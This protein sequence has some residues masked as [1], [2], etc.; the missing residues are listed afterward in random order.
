MSRGSTGP[1]TLPKLTAFW[2]RALLSIPGYEGNPYRAHGAV[3]GRLAFERR[4]F[5]QWLDLFHETLDLGW[6]GPKVEQ[7]KALACKVAFVHSKQITGDPVARE[8]PL[9]LGDAELG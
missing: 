1:S 6:T 9:G 3:H 7:A 8:A 2:C 5:E 4:H